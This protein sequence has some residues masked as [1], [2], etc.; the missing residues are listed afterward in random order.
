MSSGII[1]ISN[2]NGQG[3][4]SINLSA[5]NSGQITIQTNNLIA[6]TYFYSLIVDGKTID[7][8]KMVI[9]H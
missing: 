1:K 4:K 3:I 5:K 9:T 8:K 2:T 6:G 7:T